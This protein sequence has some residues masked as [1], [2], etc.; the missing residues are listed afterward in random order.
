V[1]R[2]LAD[3]RAAGGELVCVS[4]TRPDVLAAHL[5]RHPRPFPVVGDPDRAVYRAF[6]LERGGVGM[7]F[8]PRVLAGYLWAMVRG[9]LPRPPVRGEDVLQLG[10]DFVLDRDRLLVFAHRSADP[11]DRPAPDELV[12]QV[13]AAAKRV[14]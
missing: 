3:V 9:W 12:E 14:G 8:R 4:Q 2:R 1:Q 11:A 13:R 10:G 7:F 6:G 5:R